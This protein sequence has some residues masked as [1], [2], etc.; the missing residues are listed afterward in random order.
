MRKK[1]CEKENNENMDIFFGENGFVQDIHIKKNIE[2]ILGNLIKWT[3][4]KWCKVNWI[5]E[6]IPALLR[7]FLCYFMLQPSKFIRPDEIL[8]KLISTNIKILWQ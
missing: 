8:D 2:N 4:V 5:N 7:Q 3:K 1:G 6:N